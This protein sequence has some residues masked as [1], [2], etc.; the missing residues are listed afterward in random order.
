MGGTGHI[1]AIEK[2]QLLAEFCD[3]HSSCLSVISSE[4]TT[5]SQ[6]KRWKLN[7][8]FK[9]NDE[10]WEVS[11]QKQ[12]GVKQTKVPINSK[13]KDKC[14]A[15]DL[16]MMTTEPISYLNLTHDQCARLITKSSVKDV[17]YYAVVSVPYG[18]NSAVMNLCYHITRAH[19]QM[20]DKKAKRVGGPSSYKMAGL[21]PYGYGMRNP[22]VDVSNIR[23][24]DIIPQGPAELPPVPT[25][26]AVCTMTA[27]YYMSN[28]NEDIHDWHSRQLQ[29]KNA[30]VEGVELAPEVTAWMFELFLTRAMGVYMDIGHNSVVLPDEIENIFKDSGK[31][32]NRLF[33]AFIKGN[34]KTKDDLN[35]PQLVEL[36]DMF[37]DVLDPSKQDGIANMVKAFVIGEKLLDDDNDG[38]AWYLDDAF[39]KALMEGLGDGKKC[40]EVPECTETN[41]LL[42]G[43]WWESLHRERVF[44]KLLSTVTPSQWF[45]RAPSHD[46]A[47]TI[48]AAFARV[49]R[50]DLAPTDPHPQYD[51]KKRRSVGT[52][53]FFRKKLND[54]LK[55]TLVTMTTNNVVELVV[56]AFVRPECSKF[57]P[58]WYKCNE[59]ISHCLLGDGTI[60][61]AANPTEQLACETTHAECTTAKDAT[62]EERFC[63]KEI[64]DMIPNNNLFNTDI[65]G[66]KSKLHVEKTKRGTRTCAHELKDCNAGKCATETDATKKE[67]ECSA[68]KSNH[69]FC[70]IEKT[71]V[72]QLVGG[73]ATPFPYGITPN[74]NTFAPISTTTTQP[75]RAR[76]DHGTSLDYEDVAKENENIW[77]FP[78]QLTDDDD[79]S[80]AD[81]AAA[82]NI[83]KFMPAK[84]GEEECTD[85]EVY[86][87]SRGAEDEHREGGLDPQPTLT[88]LV[89][90]QIDQLIDQ[91]ENHNRDTIMDGLNFDFFDEN[92]GTYTTYSFRKIFVRNLNRLFLKKQAFEI[93]FSR[94]ATSSRNDCFFRTLARDNV[95]T[96]TGEFSPTNAQMSGFFA[97]T[98]IFMDEVGPVAGA[99]LVDQM[100]PQPFM[101]SPLI[102]HLRNKE[103]TGDRGNGIQRKDG[104]VAVEMYRQMVTDGLA[105]GLSVLSP[106]SEIN[107]VDCET[108]PSPGV[109][110]EM[111]AYMNAVKRLSGFTDTFASMGVLVIGDE[112]SEQ[113][114][115][116][117][118]DL[119]NSGNM[120]A[121]DVQAFGPAS[122]TSNACRRMCK[123]ST[124]LWF[125]TQV[126]TGVVAV[127]LLINTY[128]AAQDDSADKNTSAIWALFVFLLMITTGFMLALVLNLNSM[129]K[130]QHAC[131]FNGAGN[132]AG[133][134]FLF[135]FH[136]KTHPRT[137][138]DFNSEGVEYKK[139]EGF[140]WLVAATVGQFL[141]LLWALV[142]TL[143][144]R[145]SSSETVWY[146]PVSWNKGGT[147]PLSGKQLKS[148]FGGA[149]F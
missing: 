23:A 127:W 103:K 38:F 86:K 92:D 7:P 142:Y 135:L 102:P 100:Q 84:F 68:C 141:I 94:I 62:D 59:A 101:N 95:F 29:Q 67:T 60:A 41:K 22:Q 53:N 1:G 119:F 83:L 17:P 51:G 20:L 65:T 116:P 122:Q 108:V 39:E 93:G 15:P 43:R 44:C 5:A 137:S 14:M 146:N 120:A 25:L 72:S 40:E 90:A 87:Q 123:V 147:D 35:D 33:N 98:N 78:F 10:K 105:A 31:S 21:V 13:W 48:N 109:A 30:P 79:P 133:S 58:K 46:I 37:Q 49:I 42:C 64:R 97:S 76:R 138:S 61:A 99:W 34:Q 4:V 57:K 131:G 81:I 128:Y 89:Y 124:R 26:Y 107:N 132:L 69:A 144:I 54:F 140:F 71:W 148:A 50:S 55:S 47:E 111:A 96:W 19:K 27:G 82:L 117:L 104:R 12:Y 149:F 70:I 36:I 11:L 66:L 129:Q 112:T 2:S 110:F 9:I 85:A 24:N 130:M 56:D 18:K 121:S 16:D 106:A 73:G 52:P 63:E 28:S 126:L 8:Q 113:Q 114:P 32:A 80:G 139:L 74:D 75:Q 143:A 45:F 136:N 125:P 91:I 115:K 77:D 134:N 88:E 3:N 118:P 145:T 6:N